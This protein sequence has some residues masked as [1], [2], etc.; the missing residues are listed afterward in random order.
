MWDFHL[1]NVTVFCSSI[2]WIS[3]QRKKKY[4]QRIQ[5]PTVFVVYKHW[6]S[7][8]RYSYE[9]HLFKNGSFVSTWYLGNKIMKKAWYKTI[10]FAPIAILITTRWLKRPSFIV[11]LVQSNYKIKSRI[12]GCLKI[13][14]A[15]RVLSM[16]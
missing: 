12:Y 14:N 11:L 8:I 5:C 9:S 1:I 2:N 16:I 13:L 6:H 4:V 15:F 10:T 3:K 7:Y